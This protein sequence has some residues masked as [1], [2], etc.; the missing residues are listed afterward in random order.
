MALLDKVGPRMC[1]VIGAG[2]MSSG[3]FF[4]ALAPNI[5]TIY[6][7]YGIVTGASGVVFYDFVKVA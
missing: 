2:L 5:Y 6:F 4:S 3:I 1:G 7:T